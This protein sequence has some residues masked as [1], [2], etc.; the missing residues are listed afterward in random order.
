[1]MA[2]TYNEIFV[3]CIISYYYCLRRQ[4]LRFTGPRST[5]ASLTEL[6]LPTPL[7]NYQQ[8]RKY[9]FTMSV[10]LPNIL[11]QIPRV[12]LFKIISLSI[13]LVSDVVI[14]R[15]RSLQLAFPSLSVSSAVH[16]LLRWLMVN[17][18]RYANQLQLMLFC[19]LN[20]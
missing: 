16:A 7:Y 4:V 5:S 3:I 10:Y 15:T 2:F 18:I 1:M 13:L 19:W 8:P 9:H 6:S 12:N 11:L 20:K 14:I 17:G